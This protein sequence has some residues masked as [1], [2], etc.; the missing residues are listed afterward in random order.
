MYNS[1]NVEYGAVQ[2]CANLVDMEQ[3]SK[4]SIYFANI[5]FDKV[6][7]GP[8]SS[9]CALASPDLGSFLLL[10]DPEF[11]SDSALRCILLSGG[12]ISVLC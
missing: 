10:V 5:G 7:N 11:I 4:R 12:Q 8:T 9:L 2:T 6:E 1:A 3:C